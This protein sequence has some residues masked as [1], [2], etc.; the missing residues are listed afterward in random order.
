M[1][2]NNGMIKREGLDGDYLQYSELEQK[3]CEGALFVSLRCNADSPV[4]PA[5]KRRCYHFDFCQLVWYIDRMEH[6][7]R[8]KL[9]IG[10]S[11]YILVDQ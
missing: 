3:I 8:D 11:G 5:R 7:Y 6:A 1:R 9:V 2:G 4:R 10:D